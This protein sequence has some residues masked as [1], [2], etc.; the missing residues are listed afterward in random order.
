MLDRPVMKKKKKSQYKFTG[1]C[2]ATQRRGTAIPALDGPTSSALVTG[3]TDHSNKWRR[4][5]VGP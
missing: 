3:R 1:V 2:K 4:D 5:P